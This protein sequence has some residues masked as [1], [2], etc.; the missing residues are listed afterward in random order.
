[1]ARKTDQD[2][3]YAGQSHPL[4]CV[5]KRPRAES[6]IV[7][8]SVCPEGML[9][10]QGML[11]ISPWSYRS[12]CCTQGKLLWSD[13]ANAR[14]GC[15]RVRLLSFAQAACGGTN[16][17]DSTKIVGERAFES[18][19]ISEVRR[20]F[21]KASALSPGSMLRPRRNSSTTPMT[22]RQTQLGRQC[23]WCRRSG[24]HL[25]IS[26]AVFSLPSFFANGALHS[27]I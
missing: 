24:G 27:R 26:F 18:T 21:I 5:E 4:I 10:P 1:M 13:C 3:F 6:H 22:L 8:K 2:A 20:A 14:R 19:V 9:C 15:Q 7:T 11:P 17:D 25:N 16:D 12:R 23:R